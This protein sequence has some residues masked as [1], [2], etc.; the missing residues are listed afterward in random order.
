MK[1]TPV[2]QL[3]VY[4]DHDER[5]KI[6]RL[7]SYNRQILFEYDLLFLES[8]IEISPIKLPLKKGIFVPE[9]NIFAGLFGVFNDSLPDGW[10]KLLLDRQIEKYGINRRSLTALDRLA[11]VGSHGM[12]CLVYEPEQNTHIDYDADQSLKLD[13]LAAE[14]KE[15][16][17][18]HAELVFPELLSLNGSSA[19]ARPKIVAQ[20]NLVK[21]KIIH[22]CDKLYAG[23]EHW[24]IKFPSSHD[25]PD[26]ANVEYAY[27]LMAKDSGI[28]MPNT[29][30]FTTEKGNY[31]GIQR[32][33]RKLDQRIHMHSLCG[34]I[35]ADFRLPALDYDLLLRVVWLLTKSSIEVEKAF[36]LAC[37]N[38]LAYNR[39]DHSKNISFLLNDN[40]QWILSPAYDLT[41]SNGPNGEQ[42][43]T[44]M[45]EGRA[46]N[47]THL[48]RLGQEHGIQ[49]KEII[50]EQVRHAVSQ[51]LKYAKEAGV[52]NKTSQDIWQKIFKA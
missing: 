44:V 10:G 35:H 37:F 31:F 1:Y 26:I 21:N 51:W 46:P 14:A 25:F 3:N 2:E 4:F 34:L 16:L 52:T 23:F 41:F 15:V 27:S 40:Y 36:R 42:S 20:V 11:Y 28:N 48:R 38:V 43:T 9:D 45:G 7:V 32:F 33:D 22:G 29:H 5:K 8:G 6:G 18:G 47:I 17:E 24:M 49:S 50:I 13:V 19:G 39:D 30:L 12:G